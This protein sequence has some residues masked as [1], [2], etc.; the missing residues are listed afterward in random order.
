MTSTYLAASVAFI[1]LPLIISPKS[2]LSKNLKLILH[3]TIYTSG[4]AVNSLWGVFTSI[5]ALV[6]GQRYRQQIN[7]L[8]ARSF[9]KSI[10]PLV[11]WSFN[12]IDE[13][14]L[15]P[16]A[17][18]DDNRR[19]SCILIGN[20][21]TALDILYLGRI[22]PKFAA[23]MAKKEIKKIPLLGWWMTLSGAVF[24][25]RKD[26]ADAINA[27]NRIGQEIKSRR[28]SLWIFPEGTRSS[29]PQ[30]SLLPF[31]K[32]AFHL[33]IQAQI[34]IVPIVCENYY[35]LA[36]FNFNKNEGDGKGSRFER[37]QLGLKV[38]D[39]IS[40]EGLT[41]DDVQ[42]LIDYTHAYM[43]HS[44]QELSANST[45]LTNKPN[46]PQPFTLKPPKGK[47]NSSI[48][49]NEKTN[50]SN[51]DINNKINNEQDKQNKSDDNNEEVD[52]DVVLVDK[53]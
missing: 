42:E 50:I 16:F 48:I 11:G 19:Q 53:Q 40:T 51:N 2:N 26:R 22:F 7:W 41:S 31:K 28:I 20:H 44:L 38:L 29:T 45:S 9:H 25:N 17:T 34:P 4:L 10:S 3:S 47:N 49:N 13:H 23:M 39:P 24:I 8:V 27:F 30:P 36:N 1:T 5:F 15:E 37:G 46:K 33:A 35:H 52:D 18:V 14:N 43:L 21:Q 12:V 6:G 32:G